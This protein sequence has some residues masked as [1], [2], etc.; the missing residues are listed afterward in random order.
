[1]TLKKTIGSKFIYELENTSSEFAV[2]V[3]LNAKSTITGEIILPAYFSDGYM[4]LLPGEKRKVEL[5]LPDMT[6]ANFK[7]IAE[8]YNFDSVEL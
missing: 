6:P 5:A 8:G 3:K 2:A 7:V 1:M 4:N